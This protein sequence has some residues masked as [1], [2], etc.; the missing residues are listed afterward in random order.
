MVDIR[1][2]N[3]GV[4]RVLDRASLKFKYSVLFPIPFRSNRGP[5]IRFFKNSRHQVWATVADEGE[6]YLCDGKMDPVDWTSGYRYTTSLLEV[7]L[8]PDSDKCCATCWA[9]EERR[10][11]LSAQKC[12]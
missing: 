3:H 12:T 10:R 8:F 11:K 5:F 6:K 2:L 1:L 9:N 4:H 7:G